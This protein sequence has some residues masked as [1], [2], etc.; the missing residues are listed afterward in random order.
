MI[1]SR[2]LLCLLSVSTLAVATAG[3]VGDEALNL[4][5]SEGSR[6]DAQDQNVGYAA[7]ESERFPIDALDPARIPSDMRRVDVAYETS[8]AP[9]TIIVDPGHHH[10]Y[11]VVGKGRARR[12]GVAVGREGSAWS[13]EA[14]VH[15]KQQWPDWYPTKEML[16][17]RP[18]IDA[19]LSPL[20]SGRGIPGGPDNPIGA[21][22]LYLWQGAKDTLYRIHGTTEPYSIGQ[23]VSSGCIRMMNHDV[24]DLYDRVPIGTRVRVLP[25]EA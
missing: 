15:S 22:G 9:G 4:S 3:C 17:R 25:V 18:D 13:G 21:R 11:L 5:A 24:I 2:R 16:G 23:S 1:V 20:Q 19:M 10:L 7:L 6:S 14:I 12:Y 8:E